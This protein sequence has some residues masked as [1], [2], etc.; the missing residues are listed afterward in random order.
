MSSAQTG[1]TEWYDLAD[2]D[3]ETYECPWS[4]YPTEDIDD[5]AGQSA[6]L[7]A[8]LRP[9]PPMP[10][11]PILV[12]QT[13]PKGQQHW[14]GLTEAFVIRFYTGVKFK[15]APSPPPAP[16][17]DVPAP[18]PPPAA[19]EDV[20]A[21]S[22]PPAAPSLRRLRPRR[23]MIAAA[24]PGPSAD[25]IAAISDKEPEQHGS[26]AVSDCGHLVEAGSAAI[27]DKETRG[28]VTPQCAS[29]EGGQCG[30]F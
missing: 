4:G 19:C 23:G 26:A 11:F 20:P 12:H 8:G 18:S 27:S 30:H 9:L 13:R 22:P 29:S 25:G 1:R 7:G 3:D 16:C 28:K 6:R 17:G 5:K 2:D 15:P 14:D 21:S 10:Q 24:L